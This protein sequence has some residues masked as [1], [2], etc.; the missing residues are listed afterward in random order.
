MLKRSLIPIFVILIVTATTVGAAFYWKAFRTSQ[1]VEAADQHAGHETTDRIVAYWYDSMNPD[2]KSDK[3]GNA[4]DGMKLV[5]KY[6]DEIEKMQD[7]PPGT[8]MLPPDKQQ[9]IGVRTAPVEVADLSRTVRTVGRIETD[10]TGIARV[11]TKFQGWIDKVYADFVGKLVRKGDPLF[12]VYSPELV[13]TQQEYLIALKSKATL[14]S[15]IYREIGGDPDLLVK[16]A[17]QR[18]RLWDISEDQLSRLERTGEMSRTLLLVSPI[19]GYITTK[20][21][22]EN[23]FVTPEK[24]LYTI[25]DLSRI[26]VNLDIYEYEAAYIRL[27]QKAK[28][29]LSYNPGKVYEGT[30]SY[31][32][33]TLDPNTRTLKVRL[34]FPNPALDLKPNMFADVELDISAGRALQVPSEA[35]LDSG[36]RKIVFIAQPGGY[37]EPRDIQVGSKSDGKFT[38]TSGLKAGEII[39]TSGNFL[40]DSES[41]LSSSA[42]P[43]HQHG[44]A[45]K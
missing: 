5:P 45:K 41:K 3:P 24:E 22:Y 6:Q 8:V 10:E 39:V 12:T 43:A 2:Y 36:T 31:I 27:G 18:L 15:G 23:T 42:A 21:V 9:L 44:G 40:I 17:L 11:H 33:P 25:A 26:W 30:V 13:A 29:T 1:A 38:I 20:E 16:S 35:V 34:E 28:M 32:Y 4:P 7:M 19:D 37:F 14:S